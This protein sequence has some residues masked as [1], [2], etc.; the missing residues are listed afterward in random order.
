MHVVAAIIRATTL[1]GLAAA[2]TMWIPGTVGT[3][4]QVA[5]AGGAGGAPAGALYN[6]PGASSAGCLLVQGASRNAGNGTTYQFDLST[7][8]WT[9]WPDL[10]IAFAVTDVQSFGGQLVLL[11]GAARGSTTTLVWAQTNHWSSGWVTMPVSTWGFPALPARG[12]GGTL[13][14]A[15]AIF[16]GT[17]FCFGGVDSVTGVAANDLYAINLN[18]QLWAPNASDG[19]RPLIGSGT[20]GM[21][22]ARGGAS[23]T[24]VANWMVLFGGMDPNAGAFNDIW[25]FAP[26]NPGKMAG[27][28]FASDWTLL[29]SASTTGT[30]PA[31]RFGHVAVAHSDELYIIGGWLASGASATDAWVYDLGAQTWAPLATTGGKPPSGVAAAGAFIGHALMLATYAPPAAP[32]LWQLLLSDAG[33]PCPTGGVTVILPEQGTQAGLVIAIL[34]LLV[35]IALV[36]RLTARVGAVPKP[37]AARVGE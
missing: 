33:P 1:G 11:G 19:W 18:A 26:S 27:V 25:A 35:V 34:L 3:W 4:T 6:I 36:V 13:T 31:A 22:P 21:P 37:L 16:G 15:L 29:Q 2:Q 28:Y 30:P 12:L 9:M 32:S 23:W 7:N 17:Y 5:P 20:A 10:P 14:P 24:P 8:A